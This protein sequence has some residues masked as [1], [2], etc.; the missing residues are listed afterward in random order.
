MTCPP[1]FTL[2]VEI[3][4]ALCLFLDHPQSGAKPSEP[5]ASF[6]NEDSDSDGLTNDEE[7]NLGTYPDSWEFI[8][9][10]TVVSLKNDLGNSHPEWVTD[11]GTVVCPNGEYWKGGVVSSLGSG[12]VS[13][14][15]PN[16]FVAWRPWLR[17]FKIL[18]HPALTLPNIDTGRITNLSIPEYKCH[19]D[20]RLLQIGGRTSTLSITSGS[21]REWVPDQVAIRVPPW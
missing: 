16:G 19:Q 7:A 5:A 9:R 8:P 10:Y 14:V 4:A 18:S 15:S 2:R 3:L 11:R 12:Y 13:H 20:L 1:Y 17:E 6:P 21:L